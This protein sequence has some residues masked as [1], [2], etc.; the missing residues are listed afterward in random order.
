MLSVRA[1]ALT[2]YYVKA[3][4]Y[5]SLYRFLI[6][7]LDYTIT[8]PP[9]T[10]ILANKCSTYSIYSIVLV[11]RFLLALYILSIYVLYIITKLSLSVDLLALLII[12]TL[13]I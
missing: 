8:V 1:K 3:S 4:L 13:A 5:Y 11:V 6:S 7:T 9:L 12:S 10:I 2:R